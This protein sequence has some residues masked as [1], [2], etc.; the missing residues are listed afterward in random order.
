MQLLE[1]E[2]LQP[3]CKKSAMHKKNENMWK[4]ATSPQLD[5][6]ATPRLGKAMPSRFCPGARTSSPKVTDTATESMTS[7]Q[8]DRNA[9]GPEEASSSLFSP[10]NRGLSANRQEK[11]L[12]EVR[13]LDMS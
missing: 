12:E 9:A 7:T 8:H 10:G 6:L 3:Y 5:I 1:H 4:L 2:W 11:L 13:F